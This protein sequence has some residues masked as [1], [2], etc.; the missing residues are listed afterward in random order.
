M[1]ARGMVKFLERVFPVACIFFPTWFN[2]YDARARAELN[3]FVFM[4]IKIDSFV[5][6]VLAIT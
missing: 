3:C 1:S 4:V 2:L 5:C 6:F